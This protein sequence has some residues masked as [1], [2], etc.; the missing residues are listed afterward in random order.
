[1]SNLSNATEK[2]EQLHESRELSSIGH[3]FSL[4]FY[5]D[6]LELSK[7]D[8]ES[9]GLVFNFDVLALVECPTLVPVILECIVENQNSF[10]VDIFSITSEHLHSSFLSSITV[11]SN[12]AL[13]VQ[14]TYLPLIQESLYVEVQ[15][16]TSLGQFKHQVLTKAVMNFYNLFPFERIQIIH[17]TTDFEQQVNLFNPHLKDLYIKEIYTSESFLSLIETPSK[18]I[19]S[20]CICCGGRMW[21]VE[22]RCNKTVITVVI[23]AALG[24]GEHHGFVHIITNHVNFMVPIFVEVLSGGIFFKPNSISFG[25]ITSLL[26]EKSAEIWLH[27]TGEEVVQI[28]S[29]TLMF[30]DINLQVIVDNPVLHPDHQF[31]VFVATVI[32]KPSVSG[33]YT[34]ALVIQTN[35]SIPIMKT[36]HVPYNVTVLLGDLGYQ[37]DEVTF[38]TAHNLISCTVKNVT[39]NSNVDSFASRCQS[40]VRREISFTNFFDSPIIFQNVLISTC[41]DIFSMEN[42]HYDTERSLNSFEKW[43]PITLN[44][45]QQLVAHYISQLSNYLPRTCWIEVFTNVTSH[46]IPLHVFDGFVGLTFHSQVFVRRFMN[47]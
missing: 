21:V 40:T 26:D 22:P 28:M 10:D 42:M 31:E 2:F 39:N 36:I 44:F 15:F 13:M 38:A 7:D 47:I 5:S 33:Y 37:V 4:D 19:G 20:T 23:T 3:E 34:N 43:H 46:R 25:S 45:N 16:V 30:C 6:E 17:G 29:I 24:V 11:E 18:N 14:F 32:Y 35:H 27:N 9:S 41:T 12:G 1:M 8:D